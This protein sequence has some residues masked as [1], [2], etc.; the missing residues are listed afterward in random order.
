MNT[1][2]AIQNKPECKNSHFLHPI[3]IIRESPKRENTPM[4]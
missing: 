4:S 3:Q 2:R 1:N